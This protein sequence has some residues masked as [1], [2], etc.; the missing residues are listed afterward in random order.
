VRIQ[1][2]ENSKCNKYNCQRGTCNEKGDCLCPLNYELHNG[3]CEEICNLS[4]GN[5]KCLGNRCICNEGYRSSENGTFCNPVCA[6]EDDHDCIEGICIAPQV[7]QCFEGFK[8]LDS[9]N[10][11]C[12]PMCN[13]S[14]IHGICTKEG[15]KCHE[16]FFEISEFECQKNCSEGYIAIGE[17]CVEATDYTEIF[18]NNEDED[19]HKTTKSG[20]EN[21]LETTEND[22]EDEDDYDSESSTTISEDS[23]SSVSTLV[24]N[25]GVFEIPSSSIATT[26][27]EEM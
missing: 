12:V 17:S 10:C 15:C 19:E 27:T 26:T 4:C 8:F 20:D 7:C 21:E 24:V 11:T 23:S 22:N 16:G 9:R 18:G 13:P 5:G 6:F 25:D 2:Y 1:T 14:C 3:K